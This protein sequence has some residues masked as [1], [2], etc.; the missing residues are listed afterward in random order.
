MK[1]ILFILSLFLFSTC[2]KD[3]ASGKLMALLN[4]AP[5]EAKGEALIDAPLGTGIDFRFEVHDN[6]GVLKEEL[7][8]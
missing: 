1:Y 2:N 6:S 5:W 7:F 8:I 4:G 3:Q